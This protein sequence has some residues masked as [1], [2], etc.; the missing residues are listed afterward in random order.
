MADH[1]TH[2]TDDSYAAEI[3]KSRTSSQAAFWFSLIVAGLFVATL[4]F[5]EVMSQSHGHHGAEGPKTEA[6]SGHSQEAPA[7]APAAEG[8]YHRAVGDTTH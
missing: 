8:T 3:K 5:V 2:H 7:A 6:G 4:N 1:S